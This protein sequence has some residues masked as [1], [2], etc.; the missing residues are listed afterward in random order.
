[1]IENEMSGHYIE[2]ENSSVF[3]HKQ[4][5]KC[6]C[7]CFSSLLALTLR[8][9]PIFCSLFLP[10]WSGQ[11]SVGS[12]GSPFFLLHDNKIMSCISISAMLYLTISLGYVLCKL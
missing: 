3:L 4:A 7:V 5:V 10:S 12:L 11:V 6:P 8:I 9:S 2:R 1:M